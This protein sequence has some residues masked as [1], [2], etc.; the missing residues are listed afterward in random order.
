M[1]ENAGVK[2]TGLTEIEG[3]LADLHDK[4]NGEGMRPLMN[5]IGETLLESIQKNFEDEGRP[6]KWDK[7]AKKTIK[8]RTK[9][10]LWPGKIL[11]R[12]GTSGL[13]GAVNV[14][15]SND[16]SVSVGVKRNSTEGDYASKLHYG[17]EDTNLPARPFIMW[18]QEDLDE[19]K[20]S[21]MDFMTGDWA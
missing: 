15:K 2:V 8:E 6:D 19:I 5:D 12:H 21:I 10:G 16:D 4:L 17:D 18:Q 3:L 11:N 14:L 1:A 9:L 7:L 13:L 20:E